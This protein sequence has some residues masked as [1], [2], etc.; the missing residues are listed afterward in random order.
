V[1][2]MSQHPLGG[3]DGLTVQSQLHQD[4][5]MDARLMLL[6]EEAPTDEELPT[7]GEVKVTIESVL[8]NKTERSSSVALEVNWRYKHNW[9]TFGS[10][11]LEFALMLHVVLK[12]DGGSFTSHLEFMTPPGLGSWQWIFF[13]CVS[14]GVIYPAVVW[15]AIRQVRQGVFGLDV[16]GNKVG[17]CSARGL[18]LLT[19][20]LFSEVLL[21]PALEVLLGVLLCDYDIPVIVRGPASGNQTTLNATTNWT[22]AVYGNASYMSNSSRGNRS[23]D[24]VDGMQGVEV[25]PSGLVSWRATQHYMPEVVCWEGEHAGYIAAAACA[26]LAYYPLAAFIYPNLQFA[27]PSVDIKYKPSFMILLQTTRFA[28]SII[29]ALTRDA[30][31]L[32]SLALGLF[33]SLVTLTALMRVLYDAMLPRMVYHS[34]TADSLDLFGA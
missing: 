6:L 14:L 21:L 18:H 2:G 16:Q 23:R 22:R 32:H 8:A 9:V 3:V 33:G 4:N 10:L 7:W 24:L 28:L 15:Y 26:I 11:W 1:M 5:M 17:S 29:S 20:K 31:A 19:V 27:D 25:G 13:I 12:A 30:V 34:I